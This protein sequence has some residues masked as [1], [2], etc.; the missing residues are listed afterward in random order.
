MG[1]HG[2]QLGRPLFGRSG[3]SA[4]RILDLFEAS[5]PNWDSGRI[6]LW[7]R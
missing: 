3:A 1:L 7:T 6:P 5:G 4:Y 2:T